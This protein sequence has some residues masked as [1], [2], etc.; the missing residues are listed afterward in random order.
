VCVLANPSDSIKNQLKRAN[1]VNADYVII[2]GEDEAK[3]EAYAIKDMK[4]GEQ[5]KIGINDFP[6]FLKDLV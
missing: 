5:K 2:Y 6:A 3:E 1:K 4:T